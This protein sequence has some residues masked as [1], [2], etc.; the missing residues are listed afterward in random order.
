MLKFKRRN[1]GLSKVRDLSPMSVLNVCL[2]LVD[3]KGQSSSSE[4]WLPCGEWIMR[5]L[6][7][8]DISTA[9][10]NNPS[11]SLAWPS[12]RKVQ[13]AAQLLFVSCL[14]RGRFLSLQCHPPFRTVVPHP[15]L[16]LDIKDW[17]KEYTRLFDGGFWLAAADAAVSPLEQF[18]ALRA[19]YI[20]LCWRKVKENMA[21]LSTETL[22]V[23]LMQVLFF[24]FG[25]MSF[26]LLH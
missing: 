6:W 13:D 7:E 25:P 17:L 4:P 12:R 15:C 9:V 2:S 23:M 21:S 1:Y 19:L 14:Q 18:S 22:R 3:L 11:L 26:I 16:P 24:F 20:G 5:S 8:F 10:P